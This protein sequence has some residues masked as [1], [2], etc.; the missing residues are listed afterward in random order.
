M[1]RPGVG[2]PKNS[3]GK[4][5]RSGRKG[6]DFEKIILKSIQIVEKEFYR[7]KGQKSAWNDKEIANAALELVKKSLPTNVNLG[8][9][10]E[11]IF[12]ELFKTARKSSEDNTK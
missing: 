3:G 12:D 4:K 10:L 6:Y 2:N 11:I 8:G 7:K 9:K 5:G 1:S